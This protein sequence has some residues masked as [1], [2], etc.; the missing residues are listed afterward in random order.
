MDFIK[1]IKNFLR[2]W[3]SPIDHMLLISVQFIGSKKVIAGPFKGLK[4]MQRFPTR[5]M[6]LG[7]WEKEI[8]FLWNS[9]RDI[10]F[11]IDIGAAEGFYAVGLAKKYPDKMVYAFEM[12]EKTQKLLKD[13]SFKNSVTNI[14]I[15][16]KCEFK[17]LQDLGKRL[18]DSLIIMDCEGYEIELLMKDSIS[19]YRRTHMVVE[20]HEMYSPGCTKLIKE[21]FSASHSIT[22]IKGKNRDIRDWPTKLRI[23]KHFFPEKVLLHFMDEGRPYPMNWLYM[24]PKLA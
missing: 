17:D 2:P 13:V 15:R 14:E 7:I 9:L 10:K 1:N 8:S 12:N 19:I 24:K 5:P 4:F 20:V 18:E 22:E 3:K 6:L 11:I 16:G 23:L 21:R